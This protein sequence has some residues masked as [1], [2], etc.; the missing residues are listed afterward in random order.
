MKLYQRIAE[1][2]TARQNCEATGNTEWHQRH[3]ER[4]LSLVKKYMP[5]GSGFDQ[6]TTIDLSL[7]KPNKIDFDTSFHHMDANGGYDGWTDHSIT[8]TPDFVSQINLRITGRDRNDVKEYIHEVFSDV[9]T[10]EIDE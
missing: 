7:S 10:R 8:I 9:L 3:T 1:L 2:L 6:G 5:S 4:L